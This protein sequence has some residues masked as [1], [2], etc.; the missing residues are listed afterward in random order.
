MDAFTEWNYQLI[1]VELALTFSQEQLLVAFSTFVDLVF[2]GF[3]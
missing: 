2:S 3:S 1:A